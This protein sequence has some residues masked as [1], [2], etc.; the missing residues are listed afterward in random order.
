MGCCRA[1]TR[2]GVLIC[3]SAA[4]ILFIAVVAP[5]VVRIIQCW[6]IAAGHFRDA[7]AATRHLA[8]IEGLGWGRQIVLAGFQR[9]IA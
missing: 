9:R 3:S 1:Y 5:Q 2:R 6:A 7:I 4:S 8:A